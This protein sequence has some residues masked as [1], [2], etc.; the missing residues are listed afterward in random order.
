M[1]N[2]VTNI[3]ISVPAQDKA[4]DAFRDALKVSLAVTTYNTQVKWVKGMS[5][6][7]LRRR[8]MLTAVASGKVSLND[9][10]AKVRLTDANAAVRYHMSE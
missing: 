10:K 6:R 4:S 2:T 9:T 8:V 3:E 5:P 1:T 7:A